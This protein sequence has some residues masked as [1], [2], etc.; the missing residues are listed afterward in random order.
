MGN[1]SHSH[2]A[3]PITML[4]SHNSHSLPTVYI[5]HHSHSHG[6]RGIP[7]VPIPMHIALRQTLHDAR[8]GPYHHFIHPMFSGPVNSLAARDKKR[9]ISPSTRE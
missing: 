6:N 1:H 8:G 7:L 3:I 2:S 5:H 9:K 4:Y